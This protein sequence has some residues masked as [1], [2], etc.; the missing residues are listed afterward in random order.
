[1][2]TEKDHKFKN[3]KHRCEPLKA[4]NGIGPLPKD[5]W[6]YRLNP[7]TGYYVDPVRDNHGKAVER[8]YAHLSQPNPN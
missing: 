5:F 2:K 3:Y 1:M 6:N 8:K 7:I 4:W